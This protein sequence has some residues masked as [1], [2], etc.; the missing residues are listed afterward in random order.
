MVSLALITDL[1]LVKALM[2]RKSSLSEKATGQR[3]P[4]YP[5]NRQATVAQP[6]QPW[7][8]AGCLFSCTRCS[9]AV[10][11]KLVNV[12]YFPPISLWASLRLNQ[13]HLVHQIHAAR[14]TETTRMRPAHLFPG[15]CACIRPVKGNG[16][17][18]SATCWGFQGGNLY[19][20]DI[21][22]LWLVGI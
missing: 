13:Q 18:L 19:L 6:R 9:F 8:Q 22:L 4:R 10:R 17:F 15:L 1:S 12:T 20:N 2:C 11:E 16:S 3:L 7:Q 14:H 5:V 21:C